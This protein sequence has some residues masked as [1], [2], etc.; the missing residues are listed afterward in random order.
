[1]AIRLEPQVSR[2]GAPTF[3]IAAPDAGQLLMLASDVEQTVTVP[4]GMTTVSLSSTVP[5]FWMGRGATPITVPA[6]SRPIGTT[7]M[8]PAIRAVTPGDTLRFIAPNA[9]Y[10]EVAFYV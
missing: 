8:N 4:A 2:R 7:E 9:G 1:M 5:V 6:A 10:V 3:R